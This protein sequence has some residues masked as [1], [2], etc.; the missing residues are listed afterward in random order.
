MDIVS[1]FDSGNIIC[2]A[3]D[4]LADIR[5]EIRVDE[6]ADHYQWF[7]FRVRGAKGQACRFQITNAGGASYPGG[8]ENYRAVSSHDGEA[9]LRVDTSYADGVL[10]ITHTPETDDVAYAYF[11]PYTMNRH[12]ELIARCLTSPLAEVVPVGASLDGQNIDLLRIGAPGADK[13]TCWVIARQHPGETMAEWWMEGFLARLLNESD[14]V[15]TALRAKAVFYVVPNMNPDGSRRGHLR[16]NAAGANLNREWAEPTMAR[17]PEVFLI[18]KKMIETGLDFGYDVHGDEALPHN[19]IAGA[20]GIP[21]W[22]ARHAQLQIR[23][24]T[25]LLQASPDFQTEVGY[26][27]TPPGKANLS[28]GTNFMSEQFDALAMTLEMP[29]KDTTGTPDAAYG[30]SPERC[31]AFGRANLTAMANVVDELR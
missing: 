9:W 29:F 30:W 14:P 13:R 23:Y 12:G 24:K 3:S 5:L 7:H 19:F 26:P 18:R 10:T 8:W 22:D 2:H 27:A 11:A 31:R 16:T 15:A 25:E 17:S 28:M 1:N 4:D 21:K 6:N 20:E